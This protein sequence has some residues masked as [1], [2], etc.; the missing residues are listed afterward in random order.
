M[1]P[2]VFE[3]HLHNLATGRMLVYIHCLQLMIITQTAIFRSD[4]RNFFRP[5][6]TFQDEAQL[7]LGKKSISNNWEAICKGGFLD[8]SRPKYSGKSCS[9]GRFGAYMTLLNSQSIALLS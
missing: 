6:N 2:I 7:D 5:S 3:L 1:C 9:I 4:T 8:L